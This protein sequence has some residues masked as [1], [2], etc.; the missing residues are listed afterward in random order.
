MSEAEYGRRKDE[1]KRREGEKGYICNL[2]SLIPGF[3]P[4][5]PPV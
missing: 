5:Q 3:P 4:S 1:E 2:P